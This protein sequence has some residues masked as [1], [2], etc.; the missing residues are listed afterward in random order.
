[1]YAYEIPGMRFSLPAGAEVAQ[2]RFVSANSD[3][4]GIQATDST[5]IIG[6][7]MNEA[8]AGEVLEIA[9]GLV[10][11][12]AAGAITAGVKVT[13]DTAGKAVAGDGVAVAITAASGAG[14]LVTVKL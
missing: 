2:H 11:V 3:S 1:M 4:A 5:A 14:E 12:E 9:D 13:S 7:S 10:I 8:K 6:V